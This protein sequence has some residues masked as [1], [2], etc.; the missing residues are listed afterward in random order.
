[1]KSNPVRE[2]A[3]AILMSGVT[4][5]LAARADKPRLCPMMNRPAKASVETRSLDGHKIGFCCT[6]CLAKWDRTPLALKRERI[7]R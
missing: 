2:T 1:M 6:K 5:M 3:F 4:I 7:A